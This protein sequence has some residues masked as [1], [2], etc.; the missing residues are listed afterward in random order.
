MTSSEP[1]SPGPRT[2][3]PVRFPPRAELP[4]G[5]VIQ[6]IPALGT[7]WYERGIWYWA[8]RI[9]GVLLLIVAL[10]IYIAILSGVVHAAGS[11]GSAGF[12]AALA[13]ILAFSVITAVLMFRHLWHLGISGRSAGAR[14]GPSG[15]AGAGLGLL[16][17]SA[18]G[19]IGAFLIV[20]GALLTGGVVL[21]ALAIWLA[22][23]PPAEQ[24]ARR[25]LTETLRQRQQH[26]RQGHGTGQPTKHHGGRR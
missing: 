22:P 1:G 3:E 24:Y 15:R 23:V 5:V 18:G 20:V 2:H 21:A 12:L 6:R 19:A 25:Q 11:A 10:A 26:D 8:R 16:A 9:A 13:G 4:P 7:S 17:A 14:T